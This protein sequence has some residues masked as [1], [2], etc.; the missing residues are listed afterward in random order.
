MRLLASLRERRA[1]GDRGATIVEFAFVGPVLFLLMLVMIDLGLVV[2][3]NSVGSNAARDGA[4]VGIVQYLDA[5]VAGSP[6]RLDIEQAVFQRA[7]SL[8]RGTPT[9]GVRCIDGDTDATKPC[10][11]SIDEGR[12]LIEVTLDWQHVGATPFVKSANH[13]EIA[14]LV[15]V[16]EVDLTQGTPPPLQIKVDPNSVSVVEGDS[17]TRDLVFTVTRS[18]NTTTATVDYATASGTATSGSDFVPVSGTLNFPAGGVSSQTV[19]V[20]VNGD[21]AIEADETFSLVLSNP[22]TSSGEVQASNGTGTIENDDFDTTPPVLQ[23]VQIRDDDGDGK[24]DRLVAVFNE[25]LGSCPGTWSFSQPAGGSVNVAAVNGSNVDVFLNEGGGFN[26]ATGGVTVSGSGTCDAAGNVAG[27]QSAPLVDRAGPSIRG[28]LSSG[29]GIIGAGD[30]FTLQFSET[31]PAAANASTTVTL[32]TD[33]AG[34]D[35]LE[36][37]GVPNVLAVTES[38]LGSQYKSN[39]RDAAFGGSTVSRS[40]DQITVTLGTCTAGNPDPCTNF[41]GG[42]AGTVQFQPAASIVDAAGNAPSTT[43]TFSFSIRLF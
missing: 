37:L 30:S 22:T 7:G 16:G 31:L 39:K 10:N 40:G 33:G 42:S 35:P 6:N 27:S 32:Y 21:I 43:Y 18:Y 14:R 13:T 4:R 24:L 25:P 12:D 8:L 20:Q 3:G 17:G 23:Q 11:A 2:L 19:T 41:V 34:A 5:D 38:P 26:T 36:R 15:I 1:R 29:N 28:I 9:V